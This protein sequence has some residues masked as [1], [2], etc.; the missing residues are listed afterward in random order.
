VVGAEINAEIEH[1]ITVSSTV[2]PTPRTGG[3]VL[4]IDRLAER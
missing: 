3:P 2:G 4:R 1:R